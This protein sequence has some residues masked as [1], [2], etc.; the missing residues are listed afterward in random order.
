MSELILPLF[1]LNLVAF[2]GED[3]NLHIFEPRYRQLIHECD[4]EGKTFIICPHH[5]GENLSM[6]TEMKLVKIE[7]KYPNGKMDV[8]TKGIGLVKIDAFYKTII[9]KLY[10]G[11]EVRRMP[12]DDDSDFALNKKLIP[13]VKEL[14]SIVNVTKVEV[15]NPTR[16][17][18][19]QVAHKVGLNFDQELQFLSIHEEK[20]RQEFLLRHLENII[21][22]LNE[23]EE[24]K[25]KAQLNGHFKNIAA[26][27]I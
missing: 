18:T 15:K 19:Y 2:P 14:Y 1:P 22:I 5:K 12:W 8:R 4:E 24:M 20:K 9:G 11:A 25:R 17:R 16:F 27:E 21:P 7:K 13:L 6:G 26:G 23:M 10:P 3:L